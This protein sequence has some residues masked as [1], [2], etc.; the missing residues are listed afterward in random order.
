[1]VL[2]FNVVRAYP[3][4]ELQ[5]VLRRVADATARG[6]IVVVM[7]QLVE[8]LGSPFLRANARLVELELFN[9]SPGEVHR[10]REVRDWLEA[11]GF[12]SARLVP[13]RRSGG[14]AMVVARRPSS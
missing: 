2:L 8:R 5:K 11:A 13:L 6:G 9:S 4:E 14:Q 7:D 1:M 12:V 10:D 3:A